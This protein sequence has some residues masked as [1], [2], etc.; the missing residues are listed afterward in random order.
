[1][2]RA[3]SKPTKIAT[4]PEPRP[5]LQK[6]LPSLEALLKKAEELS[7]AIP[8]EEWAK[9]PEDGSVNIDHYLYGAPKRS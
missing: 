3:K 2:G 5:S 4:P 7:S 9:L 1:M 8:D 6:K